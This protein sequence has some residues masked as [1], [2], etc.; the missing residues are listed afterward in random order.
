MGN[1]EAEKKPTKETKEK[2]NME[3]ILNEY[4]FVAF[5]VPLMK[6]VSGQ[7]LSFFE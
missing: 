2:E 7:V 4:S 6:Y 1:E 3:Y 5:Q